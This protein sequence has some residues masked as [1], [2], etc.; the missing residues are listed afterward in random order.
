MLPSLSKTSEMKPY[1][2]MAIFGR[3]IRPPDF[4]ARSAS[5]AQ[6]AQLK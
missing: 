2:P 6:S 4:A 3:S 5:T 1:W